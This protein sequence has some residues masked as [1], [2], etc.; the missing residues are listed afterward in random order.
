L[1]K[2]IAA[3]TNTNTPVISTLPVEPGIVHRHPHQG[4]VLPPPDEF[5]PQDGDKMK[6][7]KKL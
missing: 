1:G 4:D 2:K 7:L 5:L 3:G 6:F